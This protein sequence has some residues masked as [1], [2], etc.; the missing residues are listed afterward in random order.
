MIPWAYIMTTVWFWVFL[1]FIFVFIYLPTEVFLGGHVQ[2]KGWR[3]LAL[4]TAGGIALFTSFSLLWAFLGM[5]FMVAPTCL[6]FAGI[7]VSKYKTWAPKLFSAWHGPH[8]FLLSV[9]LVFSF[10][11]AGSGWVLPSGMELRGVNGGDGMWNVALAVELA[12]AFPPQHPSIAGI[13]LRGYH[14]LYNF[15]IGEIHRVTTM[16]IVPLH[17]QAASLLLSILFVYGIYMVAMKLTKNERF[18]FWATFFAIFGGSFAFIIPLF[19]GKRVSIDDAFGITQPIS[20]LVSPSFISSFVLLLFGLLLLHIL[21]QKRSVLV[22]ILVSIV[23]G[24]IVGFKVYAGI[25]GM[26][27]L[28]AVSLWYIV[29]HKRYDFFVWG[30]VAL[31]VSIGIFFPFNASYGFLL[32]QPFWPPHRVMQGELAFTQWE[33]KRQTL[34]EMGA[35]RGLLKL[36]VAALLIFFF[37][38]MGTRIF[39]LFGARLMW[40]H[41]KKNFFFWTMLGMMVVAFWLPMFF[42]QPIGTFNMIQFYWYFL[43]FAGLFA[44]WGIAIFLSRFIFPWN[45]VMGVLIIVMTLPSVW[46][47]IYAFLPN[48]SPS[49]STSAFQ[50]YDTLAAEG[51]YRDVVLE[52]PSL[53]DSV[54]LEQIEQWFDR[55]GPPTITALGGKRTFL[56]KEIVQFPYEDWSKPRIALLAQ[57]LSASNT[58][59]APS[60]AEKLATGAL[61]RLYQ[62]YNI[63]YIMTIAPT[64]WLAENKRVKKIYSNDFATLYEVLPL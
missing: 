35:T 24:S 26:G 5:R 49:V 22:G 33:L 61:Q 18:S 25:L 37:G 10:F 63:R 40:S 30:L 55:S 9:V 51:T 1:L 54:Q 41:G 6:F 19:W 48:M 3:R 59:L 46:E 8:A 4:G 47:K 58:S 57:L 29:R 56:A 60:D 64:P 32:Y 62:D 45:W 14:F 12:N 20:L 28:A 13:E 42:I 36:E 43:V 53:A 44:G 16:P 52:I 2:E 39:G 27:A 15:F 21:T 34:A 17:F 23:L 31:G 38:N 7:A 11:V 50:F